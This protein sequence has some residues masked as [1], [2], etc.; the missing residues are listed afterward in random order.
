MSYE[1]LTHYTLHVVYKYGSIILFYLWRSW[2]FK[3][4][5]NLSRAGTL[6]L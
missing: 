3:V 6:G 2:Q 5:R 4:E 1:H